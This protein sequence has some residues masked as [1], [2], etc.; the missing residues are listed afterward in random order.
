M[1]PEKR[2]AITHWLLG[3]GIL[4]IAG[5][6][7]S[8]LRP[9]NLFDW[10]LV[11]TLIVLVAMV[12]NLGVKTDFSLITFLPVIVLTAYFSLGHE[13]G[14][15]VVVIGLML[16]GIVRLIQALRPNNISWWAAV[17]NELLWPIGQN[18]LSLLAADWA[19]HTLGAPPPLLTI[20]SLDAMAPVLAAPMIF[21]LVYDLLVVI[22]WWLKTTPIREAISADLRT[23]LGIQLLPLVLAP[24]SAIAIHNIGLAAGIIFELILLTIALVVNRLVITQGTLRHQ[25]K[26][27]RSFSGVSRALRTSLE[28]DSLL[29]NIYV[30]YVGVFHIK[31]MHVMLVN[32]EEP[33]QSRLAFAVE[34]GRRVPKDTPFQP[35]DLAE[36]VLRERLPLLASPVKATGDR[37]ELTNLPEARAWMGVPLLASSR[38]LGCMYTWIKPDEL[39]GR[40]LNNADL[41]LFATIGVNAAVALENA[42]LYQETQQNAAQLAR[43][44]EI[45]TLMN[46]SLNPEQVLELVAT[47]VIEV[48]GCDKAGIYLLD[49]EEEDPRLLLAHAQGFSKEHLNRSKDIAVPLS[50][51]ERRLVMNDGKTVI[52]HIKEEGAEVAP[53]MMLLAE[54]ED[55]ETY[56]YLPLRAQKQPIGILAVY[57]D[58]MHQ[59]SD[60]EVEVLETFA[61]QA[62]LAVMNAR[63]YQRVDVELSRRVGQIVKLSDIGRRLSS[64]LDRRAVFEMIVES[65]MEGCSA[66]SGLLVLYEEP[67]TGGGVAVGKSGLN[68]VAWR[69][70]EKGKGL[71][72]PQ[73]VV[74]ELSQTEVLASGETVLKS[75]HDPHSP[76]PRSQL[77]VSIMLEGRVIGAIALESD[78]L[79]AF[80]DDDIAFV[81]QLAAQA[82]V[83]IRN[84]QL[85]EHTQVVRD[86]LHAILD[87]SADGL[88]MID[89]KS[90]IVMTNTRMESFWDF[91]RQ[92]FTPRSPDQFLADP[93]TVLGEGLGY[94]KGELQALLQRAVDSPG[95]KSK[96]DLYATRSS[97]QKR[98]RY[99]ERT[100]SAVRD[101]GGE[102]V[103][104]LLLF[105]DVTREKEL[106]QA[107]QDLTGMIVHDL[108][109]PLQAVMGSMRL[110]EEITPS[111]D[112]VLDQAMQ[113]SQR[114]VKKLLNLV[115]NLL[116]LSRMERG[117]IAIDTQFELVTNI[118]QEAT[119][120]LMP[121]A[122][123]MNAV[124]RI[125]AD[126][127]LP[128][129]PVDHDMLGRVVLNLLDNALKYT[130]PGSLVTLRASTCQPDKDQ[131]VCVEVID[132]GSGVPDEYKE[133]IFDRFAQIPGKRGRRRSS[134][135]GL[136]FCQM[137]VEAHGGKIW[138]EDNEEG[139]STFKFTL[140]VARKDT[141]SPAMKVTGK[142]DGKPQSS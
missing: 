131:M 99:V 103:G 72:S 111:K 47:S 28:V 13:R 23:W 68:L 35:S 125:E 94:G 140:P 132:N 129:S 118:L 7:W 36:W 113:V 117:E 89:E 106:E 1:T 127:N 82:S 11:G 27:M 83:A 17:G 64:T 104:L 95:M 123:E 141:P 32:K 85:Y 126:K 65:A 107:R 122:Q 53:A 54:R 81:G 121:L 112:N 105:R 25:L 14:L 70:Y 128:E 69:G 52:N 62:A 19:Y 10:I 16:G 44:N 6:F 135:L 120:E 67:G 76:A 9:F 3:L 2:T 12:Q 26:Q 90:R 108:R 61:N 24:F 66:E 21:L 119:Q 80:S 109:S 78:H 42:L 63:I 55:F 22:D 138:V 57:Y 116:D 46:A 115:N 20:N 102:F 15:L 87:S 39:P 18:G 77:S 136:A 43:L 73:T 133:M 137:A 75:S 114:A 142:K 29:G 4:V 93:L 74:E 86:R 58:S 41:E 92:D 134:G 130:P 59:F 30:Q 139:G 79:N 37:L 60:H 8:G 34:G 84:A 50:E 71:R 40:D 101:E 97:G 124:I 98:Q 91:A 31:N 45:S 56:A 88:L 96:A 49:D 51:A 38:V 110:I 33:P 5:L 48:A 100:V